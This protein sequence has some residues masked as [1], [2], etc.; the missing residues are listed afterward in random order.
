MKMM[1]MEGGEEKNVVM[2]LGRECDDAFVVVV[3][4]LK[5]T[6]VVYKV[7]NTGM[8]DSFWELLGS[9]RG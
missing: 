8:L 4:E 3:R 5:W 6:A 1:M 9:K 2:T 7:P